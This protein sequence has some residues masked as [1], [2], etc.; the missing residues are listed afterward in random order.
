MTRCATVR[1]RPPA[2]FAMNARGS[3]AIVGTGGSSTLIFLND[4]RPRRCLR[5]SSLYRR[6]GAAVEGRSDVRATQAPPAP[7]AAAQEDHAMTARPGR[8][9]TP[10]DVAA[11]LSCSV[12]KAR[13]IMRRMV[14]LETGH[15]MLRVERAAFEAYRRCHEVQPP[16][17]T[18]SI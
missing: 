15:R 10:R 16:K 12:S 8:F 18:P 7:Q 6:R 14:Q 11:E 1:S 3:C 13:Q 9:M 5:A 4:Y 17:A 2:S